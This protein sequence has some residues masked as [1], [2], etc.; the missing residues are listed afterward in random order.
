M[1]VTRGQLAFE[2]YKLSD[3]VKAHKEFIVFAAEAIKSL[4][5]FGLDIRRKYANDNRT[6]E[7][8]FVL[9]NSYNILRRLGTFS[10]AQA[11]QMYDLY[12]QALADEQNKRIVFEAVRTIPSNNAV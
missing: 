8:L 1:P 11:E 12:W 2:Q 6:A 5:V 10:K 9:G 7:L 3:E 4:A